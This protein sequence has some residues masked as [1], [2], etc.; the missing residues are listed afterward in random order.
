MGEKKEVMHIYD[1]C[2][3]CKDVKTLG[4][5]GATALNFKRM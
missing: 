5:Q 3:T 1:F 2:V 4:I